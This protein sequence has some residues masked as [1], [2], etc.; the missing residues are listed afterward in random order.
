MTWLVRVLGGGLGPYLV[1]VVAAALLAQAGTILWQRVT[2]ADLRTDVATCS[3]ERTELVAKVEL[4]N[5]EVKRMAAEC[6]AKSEAANLAAV[7]TI[8][9]PPS[10]PP[11]TGPKE[12]NKWFAQRLQSS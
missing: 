3:G 12:L 2:V 4:Q 1:G 5:Q 6:K 7:R 10:L 9:K 8:S 11:G